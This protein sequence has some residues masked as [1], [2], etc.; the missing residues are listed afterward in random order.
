MIPKRF[1]YLTHLLA[2]SL[3]VLSAQVA[4]LVW[5]HRGHVRPLLVA[6]SPPV[7]WVTLWLSAAD[8]WAI[9]Q[10]LWHFGENQHL[11][12]RVGAVPLEEVLFFLV[13]NA[14]VAMGLTLFSSVRRAAS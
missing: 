13:T 1:A 9:G 7:L 4:L 2:W 14:L 12:W 3:P 11:G 8:H 10:G 6:I 5:R